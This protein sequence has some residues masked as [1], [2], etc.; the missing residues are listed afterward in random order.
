M[1]FHAVIFMKFFSFLHCGHVFF[2]YYIFSFTI[3]FSTFCILHS[4]VSLGAITTIS[5]AMC[6]CCTERANRLRYAF[7]QRRKKRSGILVIVDGCVVF[8][9]VIV[10]VVVV[11]IITSYGNKKKRIE[12][13]SE[14]RPKDNC[15][16]CCTYTLW[17]NV[18]V[19]KVH[20]L[21]WNGQTGENSEW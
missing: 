9:I 20:I 8:V 11:I 3:S 18:Y 19:E 15:V 14:H 4:L 6:V 13:K 16:Y 5:D 10:V 1:H 21:F 17:A 7:I 2:L 12:E